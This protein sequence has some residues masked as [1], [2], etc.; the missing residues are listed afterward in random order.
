MVE[1]TG[2]KLVPGHDRPARRAA[3]AAG[4]RRCGASGSRRL[5]GVAY[6]DAEVE[7]A[8]APARLRVGGRRLAGAD[9]AGGRHDARG[10]PDRGGGAYRRPRAGAGGDARRPSRAAAVW[11][12]TSGCGGRWSTS[13]RGAGL[14]EAATL[15]LW[16]T[17]VPDRLRL[18]AG[19]RRRD[20]GRAPEPDERRVGG[21]ADAASSRGS[22]TRRAATWRCRRPRVALFEIGHVFL[23]GDD[24]LPDQPARVA[25][26][27]AGEGAGFFEAKG[28]VEAL[29]RPRASTLPSSGRRRSRSCTRGGRRPWRR[30]VR[31]RAAPAGGGGV[32]PRGGGGGVRARARRP[33]RAGRREEVLYRDVISFPP[34]RQDIAVVVGE[35][36]PAGRVV[37][38][39]RACRRRRAGRGRGVRRLPRARRWGR[40][41]RASPCTSCSRRR[42]A[43]SPTPRPTRPAAR[44]VAALASER[45]RGAARMRRDELV[46]AARRLLRHPRRARRRLGRPVRAGLS[47]PLLARVR[48]A[49]L[50]GPL[51]RPPGA[52]RRRGR[53]GR[54]RASSRP[55]G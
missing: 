34:L 7:R 54:R 44:I 2:A 32:R 52:R 47:R 39:V 35:D 29:R 13:L 38:V 4:R 24:K 45:R 40:G 49:G 18:A 25:G 30:R 5:I 9:L 23:R 31:R 21:D 55:T 26:V 8:L 33:A 3:G 16:D 19:D 6:A 41:A 43:R 37:D 36:V 46:G 51:E 48:R 28:V 27:L 17:G 42:T 20:A 22:C 15:T 1:L 11:A 53:C 50:R 14:S 12:P 10:R